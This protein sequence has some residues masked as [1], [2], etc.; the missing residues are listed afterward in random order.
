MWKKIS[1]HFQLRKAKKCFLLTW[2]R[3]KKI[4]YDDK[5][6]VSLS[7]EIFIFKK[8]VEW[9]ILALCYRL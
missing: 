9:L 7:W 2:P 8:L 4:D 3:Q 1:S 5:W 6:R